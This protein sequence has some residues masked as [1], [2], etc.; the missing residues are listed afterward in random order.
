MVQTAVPLGIEKASR[1]VTYTAELP[2]S[3]RER[4]GDL[5]RSGMKVP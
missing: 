4:R 2:E 3:S 1:S 5:G